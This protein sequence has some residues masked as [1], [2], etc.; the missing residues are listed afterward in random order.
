MKRR[1]SKTK[2]IVGKKEKKERREIGRE[3]GRK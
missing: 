2:I 3:E 1:Y